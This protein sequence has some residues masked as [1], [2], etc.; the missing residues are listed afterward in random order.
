MIFISA[1]FIKFV[2]NVLQKFPNYNGKVKK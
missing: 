1:Q 2:E